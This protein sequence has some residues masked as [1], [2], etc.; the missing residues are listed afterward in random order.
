MAVS[1]AKGNHMIEMLPR[2]LYLK[3]AELVSYPMMVLLAF[4]WIGIGLAEIRKR[5]KK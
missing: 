4:Y 3:K 1:I 2:S 5:S